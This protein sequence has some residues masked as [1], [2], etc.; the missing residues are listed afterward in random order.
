MTSA[1]DW[2]P[3]RDFVRRFLAGAP[4]SPTAGTTTWQELDDDDPAKLAAVLTAGSRWVL[5][6]EID[7]IHYRAEENKQAAIDI[8]QALPWAAVAKRIAD[9]DAWYRAHPDLRRK[10]A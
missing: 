10:T 8:S 5:E 2:E 4:S 1:V 6:T 7:Q 3:V 9:R